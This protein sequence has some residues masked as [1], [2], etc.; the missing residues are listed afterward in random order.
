MWAR[1]ERICSL[2]DPYPQ[3]VLSG[4]E[5]MQIINKVLNIARDR[6]LWFIFL[7][8]LYSSA[9]RITCIDAMKLDEITMFFKQ[10]LQ[11]SWKEEIR[12]WRV[13]I[14]NWCA[15][16]NV[17]KVKMLDL[18][19]VKLSRGYL[20]VFCRQSHKWKGHFWDVVRM[21]RLLHNGREI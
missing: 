13:V 6:Y 20:I 10:K 9:F 2:K 4:M 11:F 1:L 16:E 18:I 5:D 12:L 21:G 17:F 7:G 14:S 8:D 19:F 15:K 3:R